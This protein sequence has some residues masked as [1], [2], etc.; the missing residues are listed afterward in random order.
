[1]KFGLLLRR[2]DRRS[3]PFSERELAEF[4]GIARRTVWVH[5]E[6]GMLVAERDPLDGRKVLYTID[7]VRAY[8]MARRARDASGVTS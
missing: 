8:L 1:M 3:A 4:L 2:L 5:R 6:R 7:T